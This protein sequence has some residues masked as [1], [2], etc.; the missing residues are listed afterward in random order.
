MKRMRQHS[1]VHEA[2]PPGALARVR[3]EQRHLQQLVP[4]PLRDASARGEVPADR[5]GLLGAVLS[6]FVAVLTL[7]YSCEAVSAPGLKLG[8]A[9]VCAYV[10]V[11]VC[12]CLCAHAH[13]C[14]RKCVSYLK[15]ACNCPDQQ[16]AHKNF[17]V[18]VCCLPRAHAIFMA[19]T[20]KCHHS[21]SHYTSVTVLLAAAA[22]ALLVDAAI[23]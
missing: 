9:P 13:P 1:T 21:C 11:H 18:A 23:L 2:E 4:G 16:S 22:A 12:V 8:P 19:I 10:C 15:Q 17:G 3:P 7:R 5:G 14:A 6:P 20:T